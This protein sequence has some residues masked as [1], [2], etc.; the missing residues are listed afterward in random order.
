MMARTPKEIGFLLSCLRKLSKGVYKAAK[1][2][3]CV[4]IYAHT[5]MH[6]SKTTGQ[7]LKE[8]LYAVS[9]D[10]RFALQKETVIYCVLVLL[11]ESRYIV[12]KY[13]QINYSYVE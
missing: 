7:T 11:S 1:L 12:F 3:M 6:V 10:R 8:M 9:W 4:F 13:L 5:Y 2:K